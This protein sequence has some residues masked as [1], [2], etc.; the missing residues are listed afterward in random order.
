L[1]CPLTSVFFLSGN[2]R[3]VDPWSLF[4]YIASIGGL[5]AVFLVISCFECCCCKCASRSPRN[6][7]TD[8][9]VEPLPTETQWVDE[10]PPPPY[11]LFAPPSYDTLLYGSVREDKNR[12]E[13]YV[14]PIHSDMVTLHNT[15]TNVPAEP[16]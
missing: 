9:P 14:V 12:C 6:T 1:G 5:V 3:E 8:R 11:H 7:S 13:V 4:F 16:T 2:K 10:T 15:T